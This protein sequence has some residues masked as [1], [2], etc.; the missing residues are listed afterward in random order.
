MQGGSASSGKHERRR[1][2][3][4]V[5]GGRR[6]KMSLRATL[7]GFRRAVDRW[8]GR[9]GR[10]GAVG[11]VG[12]ARRWLWPRGSSSAATA[13][14]GSGRE[15]KSRG[16]GPRGRVRGVRGGGVA[17]P[18]VEEGGNQAGGG[19]G[20][21][22]RWPRPLGR[23]PRLASAYWQRKKRT[24]GGGGLGRAGP[25]LLGCTGMWPGKT[26][27]L[28]YFYFSSVFFYLICF[29]TVLNLKIIQTMPK[30]PL[31]ILYC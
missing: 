2:D 31:N 28:F 24:R 8:G 26:L 14:F 19:Q 13:A 17:S 20:G 9:G 18:G 16:A 25:V 11:G 22:R 23:A 6:L 12:E 4:E 29:A 5:D 30:T 7:Q 21:S 27:S 15:R 1:I 10:G 3:D